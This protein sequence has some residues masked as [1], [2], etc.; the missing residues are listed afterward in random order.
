[1]DQERRDEI[2]RDIRRLVEA[3]DLS[4][5]T[6]A[7]LRGYGPGGVPLPARDPWERVAGIDVFALFTEGVWRGL[8]RFDWACSANSATGASSPSVTTRPP[9]PPAS[10]PAPKQTV[11]VNTPSSTRAPAL[12]RAHA[13]P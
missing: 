3:S 8:G 4:A 2:Q 10:P 9:A 7:A 13:R 12:R 1:M 5:A 6:T 11:R